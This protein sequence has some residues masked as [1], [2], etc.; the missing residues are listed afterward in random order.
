MRTLAMP[1]A[2][3]NMVFTTGWVNFAVLVVVLIQFVGRP[4]PQLS[5]FLHALIFA[6][7]YA[8]VTGAF[9]YFLLE[10]TV[11]RY[12]S[13]FPS[14][15]VASI[16]ILV[17]IPIGFLA[18]HSVL[19][20][21]HFVVLHSFWSSYFQLLRI[22]MP[23]GL[24]FSAGAITHASLRDRM[25][26]ME[27]QLHEKQLAEERIQKLAVES[28]LH[29][30]ESWVHPHFLFNALNAVAALIHRS[31]RHAE[32]TVGRLAT[33]LRTALDNSSQTV[34]PLRRELLMIQ[35]YLEIEQVRFGEKLHAEISIPSSLMETML[36]PMSLQSLVE[37][38]MKHGISQR[39]GTG[40]L[41]ISAKAR[42]SDI[43]I[44]VRN[45]GPAF[46]LTAIRPDHGIDKLIQRLETI[47]GPNAHLEITR[48][49][50]FSVVEMV[51]P[52]Q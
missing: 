49:E 33:L 5:E 1:S 37:N 3:R 45:T 24:L 4:S 18:G 41:F 2:V 36:P 47:F 9:G 8:N 7:I 21:I 13:K 34:I 51:L 29:S 20:L 14:Y 46:D 31:P 35:S 42:E 40:Q 44:E 32:Q 12:S 43:V 23:L 39:S 19:L 6:G 17:V 22:A 38:A 26:K 28:K 27:Q 52:R 15:L 30:L 50:P 16:G 48:Q 11:K 25:Q 10:R